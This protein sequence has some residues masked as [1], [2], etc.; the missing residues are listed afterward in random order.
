MVGFRSSYRKEKACGLIQT[1]QEAFLYV[2]VGKNVACRLFYQI[3]HI[4][5][6]LNPPRI[7]RADQYT[8]ARYKWWA[9]KSDDEEETCLTT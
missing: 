7:I 2:S 8:S 5:T 1:L 3:K 6:L 9:A 4:Q